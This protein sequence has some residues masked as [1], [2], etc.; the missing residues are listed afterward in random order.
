MA[1]FF[2][3][4]NLNAT[5]ARERMWRG[6]QTC[7]T[8]HEKVCAEKNMQMRQSC[9]CSCIIYI[10]ICICI[11]TYIYQTKNM[12]FVFWPHP[13]MWHLTH[14]SHRE[15]CN[16]SSVLCLWQRCLHCL[17]LLLLFFSPRPC[18]LHMTMWSMCSTFC[19]DSKQHKGAPFFTPLGLRPAG[20]DGVRT[21][22]A[23]SDGDWE[24]SMTGLECMTGL[25]R[26]RS[27]ALRLYWWLDS[28]FLHTWYSTSW[29]LHLATDFCHVYIYVYVDIYIYLYLTPVLVSVP[30]CF[31]SISTVKL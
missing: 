11:C 7:A 8:L 14:N 28:L 9:P 1:A 30:P 3:V 25:R 19:F 29:P 15:T 2:Y 23:A 16:N 4:C 18:V 21:D 24:S 22:S 12:L 5:C 26:C 31:Y 13:H 27:Q 6:L 10:Y 20:G 17:S